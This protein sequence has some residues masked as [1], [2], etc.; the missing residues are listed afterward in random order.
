M[1]NVPPAASRFK[2]VDRP[3][4]CL[5]CG[6]PAW[7]NGIRRVVQVRLNAK[8]MRVEVETVTRRR[9]CCSDAAC[10][11]GSWTVYEE[12]GYPH[13]VFQLAVVQAAVVKAAATTFTAVA[14]LFD[15]SR[16]SVARWLSWVSGLFAVATLVR[17]CARLDASGMPPPPSPRG[18]ARE[19]AISVIVLLDHFVQILRQRG[20]RLMRAALGALLGHYHRR[21]GFVAY[22]TRSSP[23][24]RVDLEALLL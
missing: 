3:D 11:A 22:L 19:R 4:P 23:P 16:R 6:L 2:C 18:G 8:A 7:W 1:S 13:R 24:L 9:A 21:L 5:V 10:L 14:A 20:V 17:A 12:G 15:C